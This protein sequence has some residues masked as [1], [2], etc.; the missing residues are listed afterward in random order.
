MRAI[1]L[2]LA[3][4]FSFICPLFAAAEQ[5]EPTVGRLA[6]IED[7]DG[8]VNMRSKP[9]ANSEVVLKI[10][11]DEFFVCEPSESEWWRV[12]DFFDNKGYMHRSRIRLLKDLPGRDLE[13]LFVNPPIAPEDELVNIHEVSERY[14]ERYKQRYERHASADDPQLILDGSLFHNEKLNQCIFITHGT[15]G[16][17][18]SMVLFSSSNTLD[19]VFDGLDIRTRDG[20]YASLESRKANWSDLLS[21]AEPI[22]AQHFAT[23]QGLKLGDRINKAI[24][25]FG[26]PHN[27]LKGND[28]MIYE[29]GFPGGFYYGLEYTESS[30]AF[31]DMDRTTEDGRLIEKSRLD[32]G[33]REKI[34]QHFQS[35]RGD[36]FIKR[37]PEYVLPRTRGSRVHLGF[38]YYVRL[39]VRDG[40][41]TALAYEWGIL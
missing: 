3:A 25:I 7:P 11:R 19:E 9:D 37:L 32:D 28:V 36:E 1:R 18:P 2:V 26:K 12:K 5:E 39:Y 38:G 4:C 21:K 14:Y 29:W 31:F 6:V 35:P 8:F 10:Q 16:M 27:Q 23:V 15:D 34:E 20:E 33:E 13:R 41:V 24:K 40:T 30:L 17:I 22:P